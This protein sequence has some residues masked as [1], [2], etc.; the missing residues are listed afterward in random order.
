VEEEDFDDLL[1]GS[2]A[3]TSMDFT[4][5]ESVLATGEDEDAEGL[6]AATDDGDGDNAAED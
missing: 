2:D 6:I 4:N 5:A 1:M 3:V